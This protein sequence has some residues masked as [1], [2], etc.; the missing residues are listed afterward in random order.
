MGRGG[1][2]LTEGR[3][4]PPPLKGGAPQGAVPEGTATAQKRY[5][6]EVMR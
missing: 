5:L 2:R 6:P 1:G 4:V 3:K